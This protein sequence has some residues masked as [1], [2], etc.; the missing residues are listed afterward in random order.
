M[1]SNYCLQAEKFAVSWLYE[2]M[3]KE[4][5]ALRSDL[6]SKEV[7]GEYTLSFKPWSHF[8]DSKLKNCVAMCRWQVTKGKMSFT[9]GIKPEY[10]VEKVADSMQLF[11]LV[12]ETVI[13]ENAHLLQRQKEFRDNK[14]N[15]PVHGDVFLQEMRNIGVHAPS[16]YCS[17]H[18]W[19]TDG[20]NMI[21]YHLFN[22]LFEKFSDYREVAYEEFDAID[23]E[24]AVKIK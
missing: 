3:T 2:T 12:A 10:F 22:A 8:S 5:H 17:R 19:W 11:G 4:L 24:V 21:Y 23:P 6:F 13:H 20:D 16:I 18:D 1:K 14:K 7:I 9:L 15:S